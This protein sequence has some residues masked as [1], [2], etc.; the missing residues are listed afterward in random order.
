MKAGEHR[1]P[2]LAG[3]VD[4]PANLVFNALFE[5]ALIP[6]GCINPVK[7]VK[8][9]VV[10]ASIQQELSIV[11]EDTGLVEVYFDGTFEHALGG[12]MVAANIFEEAGVVA[13]DNGVVGVGVDGAFVV[14][15]GGVVVATNIG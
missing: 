9:L 13:E 8:S 1:S 5:I 7:K 2:V 11:A 4:C 6:G 10:L 12:I 3:G 15:L 14:G